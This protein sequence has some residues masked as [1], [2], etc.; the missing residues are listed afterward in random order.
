MMND[1]MNPFGQLKSAQSFDKI[2][3]IQTL[4]KN[5]YQKLL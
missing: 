2:K 4:K 5:E 3:K 1:L